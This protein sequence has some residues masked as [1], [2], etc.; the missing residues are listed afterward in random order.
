M[1]LDLSLQPIAK[2]KSLQEQTYRVIRD[3]ILSGEIFPGTKIIETQLAKQL[4]VSR[5]PV[6]EAIRQLQ[7]ENLL[8]ADHSGGV[9][10][11]V[12]SAQDAQ[13]LYDCRIALEELAVKQVCQTATPNQIHRIAK[14]VDQAESLLQQEFSSKTTAQMLEIDYQFHLAI[15]EITGNQWL[16]L[17][18]DQVFDQMKLLRIQ[19]TIHN[20]RVLEIRGEHRQLYEAIAQKNVSLAVKCLRNHLIASKQ[21]VVKELNQIAEEA[22]G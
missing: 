1:K 22:T 17:L 11:T 7:R 3:S 2:A 16:I 13:Q 19:T 14:W 8:V 6:R 5:T 4:Q 18:L 9:R 10:V 20:P 12:V 15:A 21:R